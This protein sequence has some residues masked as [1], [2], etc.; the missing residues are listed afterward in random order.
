MKA[1][2]DES[3]SLCVEAENSLEK[4]ALTL[5]Y[6]VNALN[7]MDESTL[8]AVVYSKNM[9]LLLIA[10]GVSIFDSPIQTIDGNANSNAT[11]VTKSESE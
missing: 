4:A 2:F 6:E 10:N 5:W 1:Y 11:S 9:G 3:A 8:Q 7:G